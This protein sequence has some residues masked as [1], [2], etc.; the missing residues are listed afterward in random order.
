ML[1][2]VVIAEN[3]LGVEMVIIRV[4]QGRD[5]PQIKR[6]A[7]ANRTYLGFINEA[8]VTIS[9]ERQETHV[10]LKGDTIIGFII[11]R[12]RKDGVAVVSV[13]VVDEGHCG[14][15]IGR[16]LMEII[17]DRPAELKCLSDNPAVYF[18]YTLG[19]VVYGVEIIE[20][21]KRL[22]LLTKG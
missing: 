19:F 8:F 15:G 14:Q 21:D 5:I 6:I 3:F 10:A 11:W 13:L 1:R 2:V 17:G 4:A 22:V 20:N 12:I 18:Y 9:V 16:K 7:D